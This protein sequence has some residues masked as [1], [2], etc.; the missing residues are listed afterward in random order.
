MRDQGNI[1]GAGHRATPARPPSFGAQHLTSEMKATL[2]RRAAGRLENKILV[3]AEGTGGR[4]GCALGLV[5]AGWAGC[6]SGV[7]SG[8]SCGL[9]VSD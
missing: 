5:V 4:A 9:W 8:L 1:C 7:I 2:P 3:E 6:G